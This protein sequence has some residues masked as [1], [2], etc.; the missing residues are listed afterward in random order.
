MRLLKGS[1]IDGL[2]GIKEVNFWNGIFILRPL[3]IFKKAQL[4]EYL[5]KNFINYFN[6]YNPVHYSICM[7]NGNPNPFVSFD[8]W[9]ENGFIENLQ[10]LFLC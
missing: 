2:V 10:V 6:Q 1:G 7:T 3:L 8:L 5:S 9:N 4:K